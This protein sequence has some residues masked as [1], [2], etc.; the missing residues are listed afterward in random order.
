MGIPDRDRLTIT[1]AAYLHDV[2]RYYYGDSEEAPD[3]RSRV[4]L[5]A[6]LLDSLNYSPL[7]IG[8]LRS[9]YINLQQKYT[10]RLPI[11]TLGGNILTIVDAFY[12]NVPVDTKMSLDRFEAI[13]NNFNALAGKLFLPEVV[14]AFTGM[15]E[16]EMLVEP[17]AEKYNQILIYCDQEEMLESVVHRLR[18]DGFRPVAV[19]SLDR[20]ADLYQRSRPDMMIL[21]EKESVDKAISLVDNLIGRGVEIL[22][23]PTFLLAAQEATT[24]LA[25]LF[26]RGVEDII[27]IGK[28]LDLLV[29]KMRK[30]RARAEN[31]A[32]GREEVI[33]GASDGK[34]EE[35]NLIDLLQSLKPSGKTAK[36]RVI[37]KGVELVL[38]FREGDLVFA[39]GSGRAGV[40]SVHEV[41]SW[42]TGKWH[43]MPVSADDLP[44]PN[45]TDS[46]ESI[47][48]EGCWRL[49]GSRGIPTA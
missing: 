18:D 32:R 34:L 31:K 16:G 19:D 2:S 36:V 17:A 35:M 48:S 49:H 9:M 21:F 47:L 10:R 15:I 7:V 45:V 29:V 43:V 44:E 25:A 5:T 6:K 13:K 26:E 24:D 20:F 8:M 40:E 33:E 41:F 12:E 46:N 30:L 39:E 22:K 37:S 23:V 28:S 3:C 42:T 4:S 27:P 14:E 1:N 11:E 38:Y